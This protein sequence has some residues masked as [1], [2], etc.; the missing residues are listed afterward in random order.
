M[1]VAVVT[2]TLDLERARECIESWRWATGDSYDLYAVLQCAPPS[3]GWRIN[4]YERGGVQALLQVAEIQGVVPAFAHGVQKALDTGAEIIACFHDDLLIEEP[5]IARTRALFTDSRVGLI[6]FG[7]AV[8]LGSDLLYQ[9]PYDPMQLARQGF[10]SNMRDAE[11]HGVRCTQPMQ[12]ACLDGFSQVGRREFWE[13]RAAAAATPVVQCPTCTAKGFKPS[14]ATACCSFCDGQE[15]NQIETQRNLFSLMQSWGVVHHF[16]DGMLG[17]F[18]RRLGWEVWMLP[19]ACHHYGGRTAVGD[20]RYLE[21]ANAQ[22][23]AGGAPDMPGDALFWTSAH[24]I[25]YREFRDV[26]PI[27]T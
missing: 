1:R 25:G 11:A 8:G 16:Y 26:L 18:A 27:R 17:C 23:A 13:G 9:T 7:G 24:E 3:D 19:V 14:A 22:A 2:A 15:N 21:W 20:H 12:V 5:W 4:P 10:I 6:G